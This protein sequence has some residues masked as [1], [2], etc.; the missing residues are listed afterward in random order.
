MLRGFT[1]RG[2]L[3]HSPFGMQARISTDDISAALRRQRAIHEGLRQKSLVHVV[4]EMP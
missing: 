4:L 3:L 1:I 2:R